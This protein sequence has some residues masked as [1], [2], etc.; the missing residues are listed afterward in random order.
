MKFTFLLYSEQLTN[1]VKL[2]IEF[3][4]WSKQ[5]ICVSFFFLFLLQTTQGKLL[6]FVGGLKS[7][8]MY[9]EGV[10]DRLVNL[11][12]VICATQY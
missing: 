5:Y 2:K 12:I 7:S 11:Y 10:V 9:E 3:I 1:K 6:F 8:A 4:I